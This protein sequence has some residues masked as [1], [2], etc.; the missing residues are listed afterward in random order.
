MIGYSKLSAKVWSLVDYFEPAV[1]REL[2]RHDFDELEREIMLW[3]ESVPEEVK[4]GPLDGDKMP[5]PAG[6]SYDLQ[7]LRI[8]TR[9]RLNQV[10]LA[11]IP[12]SCFPD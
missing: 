2:K 8:W 6:P 10:C 7:R 3:Y 12:S 1:T 11:L 9:L 5:V 4:S